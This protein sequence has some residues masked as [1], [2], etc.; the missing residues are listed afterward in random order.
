MLGFRYQDAHM[1]QQHMGR[2]TYPAGVTCPREKIIV[3]NGIGV[4]CAVLI[5][6]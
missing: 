2:R 6:R 4:I 3:L 1:E 5:G